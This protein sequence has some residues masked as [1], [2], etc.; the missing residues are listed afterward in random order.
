MCKSFLSFVF[1]TFEA[2]QTVA[3][4]SAEKKLLE[5]KVV[6]MEEVHAEAL[7]KLKTFV[8]VQ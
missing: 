1:R 8:L 7:Q 2:D 4:A 6:H 5:Q 3:N